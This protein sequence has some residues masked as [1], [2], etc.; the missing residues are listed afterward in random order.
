MDEQDY[1]D[2]EK[3]KTVLDVLHFLVNQGDRTCLI[4]YSS[5][6]DPLDKFEGT[7]GDDRDES[8]F[9]V[10]LTSTYGI[11]PKEFPDFS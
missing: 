7:F 3:I 9:R 6:L 2:I 10:Y 4:E 8:N 5:C 11:N 1:E